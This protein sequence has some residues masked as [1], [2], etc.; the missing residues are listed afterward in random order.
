MSHR[1]QKQPAAS[2]AGF[3][4]H[5]DRRSF[6]ELPAETLGPYCSTGQWLC[7]KVVECSSIDFIKYRGATDFIKYRG[8]AA[9]RGLL[10]GRRILQLL[11]LGG[12]RVPE[13]LPLLACVMSPQQAP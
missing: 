12:D 7:T 4:G 10:R 2:A 8:A 6:A 1:Q 13:L 3:V 5:T 11:Q 9:H